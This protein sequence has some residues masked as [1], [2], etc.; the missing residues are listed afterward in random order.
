MK[1]KDY[2]VTDPANVMG[3]FPFLKRED[4]DK[5]EF[6]TDMG[7]FKKIEPKIVLRCEGLN[8]GD[9][10]IIENSKYS[11]ELIDQAKKMA[12]V[13]FDEDPEI[14]MCYDKEKKEF[15]DHFPILLKFGTNMCF[16]IAPRLE[17]E[18]DL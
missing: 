7:Y 5:E 10:F 14:F 16:I 11:K 2:G 9:C 1:L 13:W 4:C 3:L 18:G 15:L 8:A 17:S 12:S 6:K